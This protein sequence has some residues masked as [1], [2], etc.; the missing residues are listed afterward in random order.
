MQARAPPASPRP[1]P[2]ATETPTAGSPRRSR[3]LPHAQPRVYPVPERQ[4]HLTRQRR[5]ASLRHNNLQKRNR[6][7]DRKN[8]PLTVRTGHCSRIRLPGA[9]IRLS[10]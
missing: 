5:T 7:N 6:C 9:R 2:A 4:P 3:G 8:P 1:P 10:K